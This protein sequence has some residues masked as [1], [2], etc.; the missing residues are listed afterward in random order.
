MSGEYEDM[1]T[2]YENIMLLFQPI[3]DK[4]L[5]GGDED[6]EDTSGDGQCCASN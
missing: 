3:R 2:A 4:Y 6:G 5:K 1:Q